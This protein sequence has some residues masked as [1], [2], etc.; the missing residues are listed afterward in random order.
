MKK[1]VDKKVVGFVNQVGSSIWKN[2]QK[3]AT[4][5]SL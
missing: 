3:Q 2:K 1:I 5:F 4:F